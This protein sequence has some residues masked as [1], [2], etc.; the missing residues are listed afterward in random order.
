MISITLKD[1][2]VRQ[3][4]AGQPIIAI[5]KAISPALA[6][7][8]CAAKLNGELCDLRTVV[9][10]DC[11]LEILTF[12]D[13]QGK[14]A[15]WHTGSH[16]LAQAVKRLFPEAKLT[17][18]PAI[19]NGFYYDIDTPEPFTGEDL[20][21]IEEEMRKIVKEDLPLERFVLP[22]G[23]AIALAQK[24]EEPYKVILIEELPEGEEISFYRQGDFTDLCAGPHLMRT[25][26]LR[27]LKLLN[28]TGAYWKADANNKMRHRLPQEAAA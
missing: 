19:D 10:A 24:M 8:A 28:V 3:V 16:V 20:E 11:A 7:E 18:G 25:G 27:A 6:K 23:E 22:R 12:E 26:A 13:A 9:D 15:F 14:H 1:Q 21:K 17:I 5:A 2:S 4:E